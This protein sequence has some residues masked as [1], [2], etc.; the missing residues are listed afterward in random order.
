MASF[1]KY[2]R[3][4]GM[5]TVT[6]TVRK[7]GHDT[8]VQTF[9]GEK[10][11]E[12]M[13]AAKAWAADIEARIQ[14]KKVGDVRAARVKLGDA[15]EIYFEHLEQTKRKEATTVNTEKQSRDQILRLLGSN[16]YLSDINSPKV[17]NYRDKR[18]GEGIGASKIRNELCV[19][20]NLFK[21]AI[22]EKGLP[23][24][25]PCGPGKV[26]RPSPPQGR[27]RFLTEHQ[28][29][30]LL[31]Q[32]RKSKNK[33]LAAY[34]QV[35]LQTGMRPGEAVNLKVGM[36][37]EKDR[38]VI[39]LVT[40]NK[41]PRKIQLTE[42]AFSEIQKCAMGK[43]LDDYVFYDGKELPEYFIKKPASLF[44]TTYDY[45]RK[46]AGLDWVTRH[47]LRHTAA[48]HMLKNK[49]DLRVIA[50]VLGH[51]TLQ[52]AMKYTHP[53]DDLMRDAWNTLEGLGNGGSGVIKNTIG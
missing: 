44:R 24:E 15:F 16:I 6:V 40:K 31:A 35:M 47:D 13:L 34:V 3:K 52:M 11:K 46:K 23:L 28:I 26:W 32:C 9:V 12:A 38:S 17:A 8:M 53:D 50:E 2:Q 5:A 19:I 22:Q 18:I 33:K 39:L 14:F 29:E 42:T 4:D 1:R 49:V 48:T 37:N 41:Q 36:I 43:D 7:V 10:P 30:L 45:A 21:F 51:K 27:T 25:N 20:S